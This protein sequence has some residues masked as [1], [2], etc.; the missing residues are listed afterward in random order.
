MNARQLLGLVLLTLMWGLNWPVMKLGLREWSPLWFRAVTMAGGAL[1]LLAYYWRQGGIPLLPRGARQW[2][3]VVVLGLPNV[4]GWHGL[5][6]I[7]VAHLPAGRAAILGFTMPVFTVLLSVLFYGERFTARLALAVAAV[8]VAIA[9][10][11][12]NELGTLTG[13]PEG[14][15][16]MQAA[17]FCWAL[18]T[19]WMRRAKL[20]ALAPE[21]LLIW[22]LGLSSLALGLVAWASE[23]APHWPTGAAMWGVLAWSVLLNYGAAQVIWF[24]MARALPASTSAMSVTAIPIVGILSSML[25]G[26]QPTWQDGLAV[27]CVVVAISAV[28]LR[29]R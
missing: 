14:I 23:P 1:A 24:A 11:L 16:W 29:R 21:T 4:M 8:L 15:V 27:V 6:I 10:L 28:L 20:L 18:G 3:S 5:S 2:R 12:W 9:L 17:A 22:M 13:S 19:V 7:G 25:I 26:E